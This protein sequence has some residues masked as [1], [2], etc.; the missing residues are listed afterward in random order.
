M[1]KRRDSIAFASEIMTIVLSTINR[2]HTFF[3]IYFK[4]KN[5]QF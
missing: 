4:K 1:Q 5:L 2:K 3:R